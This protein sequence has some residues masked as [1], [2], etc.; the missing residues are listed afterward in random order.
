MHEA[1]PKN[2]KSFY[3]NL[4]TAYLLPN[5]TPNQIW[6]CDESDEQARRNGKWLCWLGKCEEYAHHDAG[7][8]TTPFGAKLH[9]CNGRAHLN[10]CSRESK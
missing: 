4:G 3:N 1:M 10:I 8:K 5:Y 9:Q 7:Q 2:V 6:N